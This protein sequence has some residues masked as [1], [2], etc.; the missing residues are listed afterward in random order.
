MT[1]D[2]VAQEII[3]EIKKRGYRAEIAKNY[4]PTSSSIYIKVSNKKRMKPYGIV[5][6]SDHL[7]HKYPERYSVI[8]QDGERFEYIEHIVPIMTW[9][10]D[11]LK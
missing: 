1:R 5:R 2:R 11:N 6:V 3:H 4:I 9:I 7:N 10:Y 8:L